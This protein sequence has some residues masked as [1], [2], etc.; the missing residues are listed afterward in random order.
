[1]ECPWIPFNSP[2]LGVALDMAP[3]KELVMIII[4]QVALL[5]FPIIGP[6]G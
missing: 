4:V 3:V 2:G 1:M 5:F 6:I